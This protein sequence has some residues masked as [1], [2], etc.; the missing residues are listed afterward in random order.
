MTKIIKSLL[1]KLSCECVHYYRV[2]EEGKIEG[3]KHN[4]CKYLIPIYG[5]VCI[6]RDT[7]DFLLVFLQCWFHS[8]VLGLPIIAW[9]V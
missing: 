7:K 3:V 2:N 9:I 5:E 8:I 4:P 1:S 6:Y